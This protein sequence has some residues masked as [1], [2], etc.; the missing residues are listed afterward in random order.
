VDS[1]EK[2]Y[3]EKKIVR[4]GLIPLTGVRDTS[5]FREFPKRRSELNRLW[6]SRLLLLPTNPRSLRVFR[7]QR[8]SLG[9]D[10]AI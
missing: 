7:R 1:F 10:T 4:L 9:Q 5:T 2:N 6:V 8:I 3:P